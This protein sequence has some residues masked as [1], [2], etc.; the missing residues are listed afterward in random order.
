MLKNGGAVNWYRVQDADGALGW[1]ARKPDG[2]IEVPY[3]GATDPF[4]REVSADEI[5]WPEG[6]KD[7]DTL[8]RLGLLATTFG[9]TGEG[10]PE[11]CAVHFAGRNVVGLPASTNGPR[12]S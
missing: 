10:L 12:C 5:Y 4:D 11:G 3:V 6:E 8:T 1:Q 9:G 2:F 7:V